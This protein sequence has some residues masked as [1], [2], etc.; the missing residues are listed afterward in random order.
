MPVPALDPA[1]DGVAA[2]TWLTALRHT[3]SANP[4]SNRLDLVTVREAIK[5]ISERNA[6]AMAAAGLNVEDWSQER[7][8]KAERSLLAGVEFFERAAL[9]KAKDQLGQTIPSVAGLTGAPDEQGRP[10]KERAGRAKAPQTSFSI[11]E[12]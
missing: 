9:V 6:A 4:T 5:A 10:R 7:I 12:D 3:R 11:E 8:K 1:L 2:Q